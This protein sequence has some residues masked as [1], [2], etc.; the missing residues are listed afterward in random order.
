MKNL[1]L[2]VSV[3]TFFLAS[4]KSD[5]DVNAPYKDTTVIYGLLNVKDSVHMIKVNKA[6]L[7]KESAY[8]MAKVRDSSEYK[9][10]V[11]TI[12]KWK[13]GVATADAAIVLKDTVI[14]NKE[15]GIFYAP[16][17]KLYYF[18]DPLDITA[19]YNL[20]VALSDGKKA[21]ARTGVI[22]NFFLSGGTIFG[23][24]LSPLALK[25]SNDKYVDLTYEWRSVKH[26]KSYQLVMH[27]V[28]DE[29]YVDG[30]SATKSFDWEF[31]VQE[32]FGVLGGQEM[33]QK[34]EGEVFYQEIAS[35]IKSK[36]ES[37]NVKYRRFGHLAFTLNVAGEDFNTYLQVNKPI[38]GVVFDKPEYT[39][40]ENGIGIFSTRVNVNSPFHKQINDVSLV[41]LYNGKYT[42]N[43]GFCA[44]NGTYACQ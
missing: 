26:G 29:Y 3:I 23:N 20:E 35:K 13:N 6:F 39:N 17:Q 14:T 11:V 8:T 43:L 9:D 34:I 16:D 1:F 19:E 12:K 37:P 18:T 10:A 27:F 30:S 40:V 15:A 4:C 32:A 42:K 44:A 33:S 41:E 5:L 25:T 28:Y 36:A 38:T 2:L 21:T 22:E 31:D 24:S 7:G